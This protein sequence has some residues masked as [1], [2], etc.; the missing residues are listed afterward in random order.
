VRISLVSLPFACV[1]SRK[2]HT[3]L[4]TPP[5]VSFTQENTV[6]SKKRSSYHNS[7]LR[8]QLSQRIS[9]PL[10]LNWYNVKTIDNDFQHDSHAHPYTRTRTPI[11]TTHSLSLSLSL[12]LARSLSFSV[13]DLGPTPSYM[14]HEYGFF[15]NLGFT[16]DT[17]WESDLFITFVTYPTYAYR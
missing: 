7:M 4:Y 11:P 12:S 17:S 15:S 1:I 5:P 6:P 9:S 14:L 3:C 8:E 10:Q 16:S 13:C 2:S